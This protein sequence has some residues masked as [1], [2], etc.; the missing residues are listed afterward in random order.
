VSSKHGHRGYAVGASKGFILFALISRRSCEA[1]NSPARRTATRLARTASATRP[2]TST[3]R[4]AWRLEPLSAAKRGPDRSI[5]GSA[6]HPK[7]PPYPAVSGLWG[8]PTLINNVETY[9]ILRPSSAM[10]ASGCQHGLREEQGTRYLP[11]PA[12][13]QHRLVE[14]PMASSCAR[15]SRSSAAAC[16]MAQPSRRCKP[17]GLRGL[18]PREM[19]DVGVSYDA[20]V[21]LGSIMGSGGMIVMDTHPAW[22]TWRSSSSSA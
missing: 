6:A 17:A 8:K 2:S 3:L 9:A 16:P 18:H 14:V 11:S 4:S 10:A 20:L 22:S 13:C 7:R 21:R 12:R 5:E 1:H 19:L 15:S